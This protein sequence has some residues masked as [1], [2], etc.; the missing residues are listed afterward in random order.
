MDSGHEVLEIGDWSDVIQV[1]TQDNQRI[2]SNTIDDYSVTRFSQDL[3][4][5]GNGQDFESSFISTYSC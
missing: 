4:P 1:L 5:V 3:S 2:S